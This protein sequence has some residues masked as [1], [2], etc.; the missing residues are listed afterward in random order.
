MKSPACLFLHISRHRLN[1]LISFHQQ[2]FLLKLKTNR[3]KTAILHHHQVTEKEES[4]HFLWSD[5]KANVN[6]CYKPSLSMWHLG[7]IKQL[8]LQRVYVNKH[9]PFTEVSVLVVVTL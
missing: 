7:S 9:T 4:I 6:I 5:A 2:H 8:P 1:F 3:R